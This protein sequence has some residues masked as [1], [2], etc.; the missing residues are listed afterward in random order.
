MVA[1]TD[2]DALVVWPVMPF[3][4]EMNGIDSPKSRFR[5]V[6]SLTSLL[7]VPVPWAFT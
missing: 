5:A 7:G 1:S 3:V 2:P 6:L 4:D